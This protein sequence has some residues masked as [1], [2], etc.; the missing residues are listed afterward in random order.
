MG[1][2]CGISRRSST[3]HGCCQKKAGQRTSDRLSPA[4]NAMGKVRK[5]LPPPCR[6]IQHRIIEK[7]LPEY[8][9][10]LRTGD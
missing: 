8:E 6:L 4:K 5:L 7:F 10:F 2:M 9:R 1:S 3:G